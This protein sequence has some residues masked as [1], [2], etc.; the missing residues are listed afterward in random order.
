MM[1]VVDLGIRNCFIL[2]GRILD[3]MLKKSNF[4]YG[5]GTIAQSRVYIAQSRV[6]L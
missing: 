2:S 1:I 6:Y 4:K 5:P 3:G